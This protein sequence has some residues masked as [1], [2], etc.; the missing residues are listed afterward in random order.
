ME[1]GRI[2]AFRQSLR[3]ISRGAL[4]FG[5]ALLAFAFAEPVFAKTSTSSTSPTCSDYFHLLKRR[6]S[7]DFNPL[8][9][10]RHAILRTGI[11]DNIKE[12]TPLSGQFNG[13]RRVF[14]KKD[15]NAPWERY[16]ETPGFNDVLVN[17]DSILHIVGSVNARKFGF[18]LSANKVVM[19]DAIEI[20]NAIA[21][22]NRQF[23][24]GDSRRL[25]ITFYETG[26]KPLMGDEY[27]RRFLESGE[28]PMA[29]SGRLHFHDFTAHVGAA[30]MPKE[31]VDE[32]RRRIQVFSGFSDYLK[33]NDPGLHRLVS[34]LYQKR[35][36]NLI[37][38]HSNR[39]QNTL[40]EAAEGSREFN[41]PMHALSDNMYAIRA[42]DDVAHALIEILDYIE[43]SPSQAASLSRHVETYMADQV[44]KNPSLGELPFGLV[45]PNQKRPEKRHSVSINLDS[46]EVR[47]KVAEHI[48][49][50][51][52]RR[53]RQLQ[54]DLQSWS[55]D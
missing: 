18:E 36:D 22:F 25:P 41:L 47:K 38:T 23:P 12:E 48:Q 37:D 15:P 52:H 1:K 32:T 2:Q 33:R 55:P 30:F 4:L 10:I 43:I 24:E 40:V 35:T 50:L 9:K 29:K 42:R 5:A 45:S 39:G 49:Q 21:S 16:F 20:Q 8:L 19:P 44:A 31:I 28:L 51:A 46:D 54:S 3:K 53:L 17:P 26:N 34:D 27:R 7:Y 14:T 13:T 11:A 6:L